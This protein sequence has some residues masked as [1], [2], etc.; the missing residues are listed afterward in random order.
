MLVLS[1]FFSSAQAQ[2]IVF[3]DFDT[4]TEIGE[5]VYTAGER[6]ADMDDNCSTLSNPLQRHTDGDIYGNRCDP[7]LN[8]D[9]LVTVTDFLI[10]RSRL[11][12]TDP[13]ADLNGDGVVT[14][15]DFLI[16]RGFLNKP[17]GPGP[18]VPD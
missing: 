8:N 1:V 16:L 15:T 17:P 14:V 6:T 3:L 13:D 9:G 18:V 4:Y 5:H 11:N 12:T 7:D 10:L 2:Q